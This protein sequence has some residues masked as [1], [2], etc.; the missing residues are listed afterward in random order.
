MLSP[1]TQLAGRYQ[2]ERLIAHGGTSLVY[3]GKALA[4]GDA[5][6]AIKEQAM[7]FPDPAMRQAALVQFK[8]E[9]S[10]LARL[11]HPGIVGVK[12]CF[13]EGDSMF[14]VLEHIDGRTLQD[15]VLVDKRDPPIPLILHWG[16][17][18]CDILMYLHGQQTPVLVRDLKPENVMM[19][20]RGRLRLIDFG[21][22][23]LLEPNA[24][25]A[26]LVRGAGT[27][28]YAPPEQYSGQTEPRSDIYALGATLFA[29]LTCRVPPDAV[30]VLSG[31]D[32][33]PPASAV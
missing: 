33:L 27:P 14:I 30:A 5:P 25:T 6:V 7:R 10:L 9:A 8:Q 19:D 11:S 2:I 13:P 12:D 3:L 24:H 4:L 28:G 16:L 18:L 23:R 26:T 29:L 21:L 32:A 20:R 31:M 15:I 17:Q 22:A 1:G